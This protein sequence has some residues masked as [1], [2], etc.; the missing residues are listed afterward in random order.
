MVEDPS[1]TAKYPDGI[2]TIIEVTMRS[3]ARQS[4]RVDY[5]RG[6]RGNPMTDEEVEEKF[7]LQTQGLL[8]GDQQAKI[9][10]LAWELDKLSDVR[11]LLE[12]TVI[13]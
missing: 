10:E 11:R 8:D 5:P 9:L 13:R 12:A 7:R 4:V 1:L 3:G 6:H 2:P